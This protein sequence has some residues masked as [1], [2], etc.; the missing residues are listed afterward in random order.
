MYCPFG[1]SGI[2]VVAFKQCAIIFCHEISD[3]F[4]NFNFESFKISN[5]TKEEKC[6]EFLNGNFRTIEKQ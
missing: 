1:H 4:L 3:R 6:A 2:L 5:L